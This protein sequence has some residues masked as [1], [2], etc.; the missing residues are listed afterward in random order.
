MPPHEVLG[1][2]LASLEAGGRLRRSEDEVAVGLQEIDKPV[3][4]RPLGTYDGEVGTDL[5]REGEQIAGFRGRGA[6]A[7]GDLGAT[8]V[9]GGDDDFADGRA[10]MEPPGD[11]VFASATANNEDFHGSVSWAD[12]SLGYL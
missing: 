3:H 11:C 10:A 7:G 9:A 1:E 8:G 12:D 5:I 4:E 6:D 2:D